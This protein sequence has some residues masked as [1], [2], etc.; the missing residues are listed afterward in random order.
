MTSLTDILEVVLGNA[1]QDAD[2]M[3]NKT[4]AP[5]HD[6]AHKKYKERA[7]ARAQKVIDD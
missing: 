3:A 4:V 1:W 6:E 7:D 2:H 5:T